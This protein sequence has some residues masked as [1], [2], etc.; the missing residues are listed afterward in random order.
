M[1][2]A[3][4]GVADQHRVALVGV[5][6][7]IGAVGDLDVVK[8]PPGVQAQGLVRP[9]RKRPAVLREIRRVLARVLVHQRLG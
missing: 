5:Q 7:S 6:R 3:G 9:E 8:A 2:I 1:L 4:Q